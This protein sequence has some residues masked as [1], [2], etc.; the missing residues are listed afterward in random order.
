MWP[1]MGVPMR[2][3]GQQSQIHGGL[4]YRVKPRFRSYRATEGFTE[5]PAGL[6]S[7]LA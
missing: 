2:L 3:G 1:G 5:G 7:L 6:K 4:M